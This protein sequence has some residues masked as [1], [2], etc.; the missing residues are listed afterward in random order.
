MK[1]DLDL[2]RKILFEVESWPAKTGPMVVEIEGYPLDAVC[3]N[4]SLLV[5]DGF[6]DGIDATSDGDAVDVFLLRCL[7]PRGHD[8]V[9]L[10]RDDTTW[11][12]AKGIA[13]RSGRILTMQAMKTILEVLAKGGMAAATALS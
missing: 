5:K 7:T 3:Y 13:V 10:L 12:E 2:C 1:R 8:L 9:D 11:N 4:A 6:I